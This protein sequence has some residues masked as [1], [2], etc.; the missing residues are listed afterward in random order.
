MKRFTRFHVYFLNM[1]VTVNSPPAHRARTRNGFT[2]IELLVVIAIIAILA[3][4]LLP[5]LASAKLKAKSTQC[6]SQL[7]QC[8]I[9]MQMYLSDYDDKF[10]WGDPK[11][12][13]L[14][15]DGMEWFVWA[16]RASNNVF[17]GQ[18]NIFNRIDR[19]L[20]HYG[21]TWQSVICPLDQGRKDTLP[22]KLYE[23][24]GNSYMFNCFGYDPAT[25]GLAGQTA[26]TVEEPAR[27]VL[28]AD[29]VVL[30]PE[31]PTGWHKREPAGNV[32][33]VDGHVEAHDADTV[34]SLVW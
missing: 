8:G 22:H 17:T 4:M 27:M 12:P 19:P 31:N 11:S 30:F 28:F 14:G 26:G 34:T 33:L 10:F 20:N 6:L 24:V 9:A 32:L 29:N 13:S 25:G 2:L 7:R 3:A 1:E 23:W 21:L 15:T 16:G 5:S 18:A